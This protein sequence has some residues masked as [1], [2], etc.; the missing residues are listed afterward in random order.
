VWTRIGYSGRRCMPHHR[1]KPPRHPAPPTGGRVGD[2]DDSGKGLVLRPHLSLIRVCPRAR[3]IRTTPTD[4]LIWAGRVI[5]RVINLIGLETRTR[6]RGSDCL[7]QSKPTSELAYRNVGVHEFCPS[8]RGCPRILS[9]NSDSRGAL[10]NDKLAT[11]AFGRE[12]MLPYLWV[13]DMVKPHE[14]NDRHR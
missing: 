3:F 11:V 6:I 10:S 13:N 9:T 14:D 1:R 7:R 5:H 12:G 8:K 4:L 2:T